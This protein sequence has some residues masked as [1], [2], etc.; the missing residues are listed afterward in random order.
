MVVAR[1][2]SD[3]RKHGDVMWAS[4]ASWFLPVLS[5]AVESRQGTS[6]FRESMCYGNLPFFS[7]TVRAPVCLRFVGRT[8]SDSLRTVVLAG[9]PGSSLEC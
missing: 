7:G 5:E 2:P 8:L 4:R 9:P 1:H 3:I 6:I